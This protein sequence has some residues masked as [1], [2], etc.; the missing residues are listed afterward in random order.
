MTGAPTVIGE[1]VYFGLVATITIDGKETI[2]FFAAERDPYLEYDLSSL[3]YR[4]SHPKKQ[5][6]AIIS[7]LPLDTGNGGMQA[8][9]QGQSQPMMIYAELTQTYANQILDPAFTTI[10]Q[11]ADV[12]L[13]VYPA[14]LT[15]QQNYAIDQ[16]V[17]GGGRALVFVDPNSELAAASGGGMGG[18]G[19]AVSSTLPRLFQAW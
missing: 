19:G 17:L 5:N 18:G 7:S 1:V 8:M 16:F 2:P 3:I 10:P 9:V 6:I 12:L 14:M 15:V 13:I 4:L 11:D